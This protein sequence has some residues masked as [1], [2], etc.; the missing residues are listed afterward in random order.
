MQTAQGKY[1]PGC[2]HF[3]IYILVIKTGPGQ[4]VFATIPIY[5]SFKSMIPPPRTISPS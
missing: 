3:Y 5:Y 2:L 1:A 4:N